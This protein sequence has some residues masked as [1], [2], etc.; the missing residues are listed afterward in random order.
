MATTNPTPGLTLFLMTEKGY[1]VLQYIVAHLDSSVVALVV[2]APDPTSLAQGFL[3]KSGTCARRPASR[4]S[5]AM[6]RTHRVR[7]GRVVALADC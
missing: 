1:R 7:A 5:A 2:G 3:S 4:F 6:C